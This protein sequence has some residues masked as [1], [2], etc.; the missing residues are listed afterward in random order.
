MHKYFGTDVSDCTQRTVV[1][2]RL[3][4]QR[5]MKFFKEIRQRVVLLIVATLIFFA[6]N[7]RT[8]VV[9]AVSGDEDFIPGE[10]VVKLTSSSDLAGIASQHALNPTPLDQFGSRPIYRLRITDGARVEDRVN[11]LLL[12][13]R[14]I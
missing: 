8:P 11:Q 13:T 12:D 9:H 10:V 3:A 4:S 2:P 1:G 7:W 14:V 5:N 6:A